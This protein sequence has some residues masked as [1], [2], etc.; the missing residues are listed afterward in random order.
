MRDSVHHNETHGFLLGEGAFHI[1]N[2]DW[3]EASFVLEGA[4]RACVNI[5]CAVG[6]ETME[7]PEIPVPDWLCQGNEA[8]MERSYERRREIEGCG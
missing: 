3:E 6:S 5:D 2:P 7:K 4:V 1:H 8:G